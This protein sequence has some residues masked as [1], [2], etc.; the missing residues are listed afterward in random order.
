VVSALAVFAE[1][2]IYN[3]LTRHISTE[4]TYG[5]AVGSA[6]SC[7]ALLLGILLLELEIP[8]SVPFKYAILLSAFATVMRYF[9]SAVG[10]SMANGNRENVAIYGAG[11]TGIQLMEAL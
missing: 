4:A 11:G 1:R 3:N 7:L 5:I 2:G 8:R 10:Q 6:T 9:I